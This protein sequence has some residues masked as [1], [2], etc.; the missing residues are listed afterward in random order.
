MGGGSPRVLVVDDDDAIRQL[1]VDLL[2]DAG[3]RVDEA[4]GGHDALDKARNGHPDVILLDKL[5]PDGDGT[6]FATAY[7]GSPGPHAPIVGL[8]AARDGE[9]WS[10]EIGAAAYVVKPFDIQ[11]LLSVVAEQVPR[12][13]V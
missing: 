5:M 4:H 9:A 13:D 7:A 2:S 10:S 1:L 12:R 11:H 3:Y 8:C 6:A